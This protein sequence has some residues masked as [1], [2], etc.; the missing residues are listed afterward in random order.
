[1]VFIFGLVTVARLW[2]FNLILSIIGFTPHFR[3]L[4]RRLRTYVNEYVI[5]PQ[6]WNIPM[7]YKLAYFYLSIYARTLHAY[8]AIVIFWCFFDVMWDVICNERCVLI[9]IGVCSYALCT[10]HLVSLW[11]G[12]EQVIRVSKR[13][14]VNCIEL[15]ISN[16]RSF[17]SY[18]G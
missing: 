6:R 13:K 15:I 17:F 16:A 1:M 3:V 14:Y 12:Y 5:Y 9:V 4:I 8:V 11:L 2:R 18:P 7:R 10:L